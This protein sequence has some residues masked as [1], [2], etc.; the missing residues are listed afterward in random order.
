MTTALQ[1]Y[2]EQDITNF[3]AYSHKVC[4]TTIESKITADLQ[5]MKNK[6]DPNYN[7]GTLRFCEVVIHDFKGKSHTVPED[8]LAAI[9][10]DHSTPQ[11]L[12]EG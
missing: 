11:I 8:Y 1:I 10:K 2:K 3:I 9:G 7:L 4:S 6:F 12:Q 5:I